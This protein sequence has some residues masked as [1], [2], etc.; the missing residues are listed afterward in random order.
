[1]RVPTEI[2]MRSNGR[3]PQDV[4]KVP[5]QEILPLR[6][7][8]RV[9]GKADSISEVECLQEMAILFACMKDNEF[10]EKYCQKEISNFQKCFKFHMDKNFQAKQQENLGIIVPGRNLN[11]RQ[12]NKYMRGYPNPL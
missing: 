8:N 3:W 4:K 11:Y 7:K 9:S 2:L 5:F 10:A 12:L 1:M 6:L